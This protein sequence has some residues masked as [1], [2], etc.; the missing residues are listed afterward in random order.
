MPACMCA[1]IL[2]VC[3]CFLHVC[4]CVCVFVCLLLFSA[5]IRL[6][7]HVDCLLIFVVPKVAINISH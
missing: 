7:F 2:F 3:C 5:K 6:P 1:C 4:V